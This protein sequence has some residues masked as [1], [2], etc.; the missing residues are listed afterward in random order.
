M[1]L[2]RY[3]NPAPKR[4]GK[5]WTILVR[6]DVVEHEQRKRKVRRVVLGPST[7]TRAEAERLRDDYLENINQASVGIG[8]AILFRDF[9]R[10]YERDVLP[11]MASTTQ[12]RS[13][14]VLKVHLEPEFGD[15]MLR[16][17]SSVEV[18]QA[19]FTRLQARI[20]ESE[21]VDKI[22]DVMSAV[23]GRPW[24]TNG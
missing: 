24:C 22:R 11:A 4:R 23:L 6:E 12:N 8:G 5:Q 7:L 9:A 21:T 1:A 3:Q 10:I 17:L 14:S 19:Y 20:P 18:L 16:E 13:K 2:R 15:K